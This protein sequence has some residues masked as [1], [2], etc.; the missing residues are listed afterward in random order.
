MGVG[1]AEDHGTWVHVSVY[2]VILALL[3]NNLILSSLLCSRRDGG[4]RAPA[5]PS[6]ARLN[7]HACEMVYCTPQ[8]K[9]FHST[10]ACH[11]LARA[12][13]GGRERVQAL[14]PCALCFGRTG[15]V[16][17]AQALDPLCSDA[18]ANDAS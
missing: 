11:T 3:V 10:N 9:K 1:V 15:A 2:V 17:A 14:T 12:K 6:T 7:G 18:F 4:A 16:M 8:G 5:T 13:D